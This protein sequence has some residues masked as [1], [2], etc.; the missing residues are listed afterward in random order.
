LDNEITE[1]NVLNRAELSRCLA[2]VADAMVNRIM[3][4]NVPRSVKEDL[5]KEL[6]SI[7]VVLEEVAHGQSRLPR[8]KGKRHD[9][10]ESEDPVMQS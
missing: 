10:D 9:E 8:R 4:A 7:P 1:G 5:L 3:V 2:A 6:P